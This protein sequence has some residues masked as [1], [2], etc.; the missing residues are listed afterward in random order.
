MFYLGN[1]VSNGW[2]DPTKRV[3]HLGILKNGSTYISTNVENWGWTME[4]ILLSHKRVKRFTILREPYL[5]NR[6]RIW[7][8]YASM[9]PT[10]E[11]FCAVMD[12]TTENY[13]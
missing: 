12:Q 7:E 1:Y 2:T 6:N 4:S 5:V 8:N 13:E 11:S 9:F 3:Q 10:L